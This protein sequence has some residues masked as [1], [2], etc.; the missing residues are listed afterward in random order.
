MLF[1]YWWQRKQALKGDALLPLEIHQPQ[2]FPVPQLLP[3]LDLDKLVRRTSPTLIIGLGG[4]GRWVLTYLKKSLMETNYGIMPDT[5]KLL[6]IDTYEGEI[7]GDTA[8][9][10]QVGGVKLHENECLILD[11]GTSTP[12][13]LLERTRAMNQSPDNDSHLESWWLSEAFKKL[14]TE[15]FK[16]SSGTKQR[17]PFGRMALF[18]DLEKGPQNSRFWNQLAPTINQ[19]GK[20]TNVFVA[21][22][23]AGGMGSGMFI[24]VAYLVRHIAQHHKVE[25]VTVNAALALQNTFAMHNDTLRL[26]NPNTFASLR[27]L[28]RFLSCRDF[29]FPMIYSPDQKDPING[30]LQAPLLDNCYVF[31]GERV[32]FSLQKEF[33]EKGV[34]PSI[35]DTIHTFLYN[36]PGSAFDQEVRQRKAV[37]ELEREESGHG[38]VSSLGTFVF[39]LP[40]FEFVQT[41]KYRFARKFLA[42]LLGLEKNPK[43]QWATIP[44]STKELDA[45][46]NLLNQYLKAEG[47]ERSPADV[48]QTVAF[49]DMEMLIAIIQADRAHKRAREYTR[50]HQLNFSRHLAAYLMDLLNGK[51]ENTAVDRNKRFSAAVAVTRKLDT[52]L[53]QAKG[54]L[55]GNNE[56]KI[57]VDIL[58]AYHAVTLSALKTSNP[59]S[60]PFSVEQKPQKQP[61]P[62]ELK[63]IPQ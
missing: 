37:G 15:D 20:G 14:T 5:V 57:A 22:S 12:G 31:D 35:S 32:P 21:S 49:G 9:L 63:R 61:L 51:Q 29:N 41:F 62:W 52:L 6:L 42:D 1:F 46:S 54:Q 17:R 13:K 30:S 39:R 3:A 47:P 40:M 45:L 43:G 27:E 8:R 44:L 33:P 55:T 25:G 60:L 48:L 24:D 28:D 19:L 53:Q 10:V 4:T 36:A 34:F 59:L 58:E 16:I 11:E 56:G 38:V 23:L 50:L 7:K 26:T 2:P 18:L